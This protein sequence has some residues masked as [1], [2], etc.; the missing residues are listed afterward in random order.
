MRRTISI[1]VCLAPLWTAPAAEAK[2]TAVSI[3]R[4]EAFAEGTT[5]GETGVYERVIGTVKGELDPADQHN[6]GIVNLENAPHNAR[7][8]VEYETEFNAWLNDLETAALEAEAYRDIVARYGYG[9][10]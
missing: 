4:I 2:I 6:R 5:F 10:N 8:F 1:C 7:G 9:L 3:D